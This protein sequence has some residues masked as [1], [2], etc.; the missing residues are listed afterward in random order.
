[1]KY[2]CT[3]ASL[4]PFWMVDGVHGVWEEGGTHAVNETWKF[5][6]EKKETNGIS[7]F[8]SGWTKW[9]IWLASVRQYRSKHTCTCS[10]FVAT[11]IRWYPRLS[12]RHTHGN[13]QLVVFNVANSNRLLHWTIKLWCRFLSLFLF[14]FGIRCSFHKYPSAGFMRITVFY[15]TMCRPLVK[16]TKARRSLLS[17]YGF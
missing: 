3:F 6:G 5:A 10:A 13:V 14:I 15:T 12:C 16:A 7:E 2:C 11:Q 8:G 17:C 4:V 9:L 1:M